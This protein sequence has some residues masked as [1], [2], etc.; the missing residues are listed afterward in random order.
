MLAPHRLRKAWDI[1]SGKGKGKEEDE[2]AGISSEVGDKRKRRKVI[3]VDPKGY[4]ELAELSCLPLQRSLTVQIC[5]VKDE[6]IVKTIK[7][8]DTK[9]LRLRKGDAGWLPEVR[10]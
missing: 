2:L 9:T 10:E 5:D 8:L 7:A 4:S 6:T 3:I 1:E